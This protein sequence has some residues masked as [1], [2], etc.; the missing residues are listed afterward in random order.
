[1][2]TRKTPDKP[3]SGLMAFSHLSLRRRLTPIVRESVFAALA[4][5]GELWN[6]RGERTRF[7]LDHSLTTEAAFDEALSAFLE[8]VPGV[9][10]ALD[11]QHAV[12]DANARGQARVDQATAAYRERMGYREPKP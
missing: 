2:P 8:R 12:H 9:A 3:P 10:G 6:L 1:M 4:E 11:D 5:A 7:G